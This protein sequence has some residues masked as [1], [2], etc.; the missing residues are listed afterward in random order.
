MR[1][2]IAQYE[3]ATTIRVPPLAA[4][5]LAS[6][7]RREEDVALKL[8]AMRRPPDEAAAALAEADLAG[9]SLYTWNARYALEVAVQALH[10][11]V[12]PF[13]DDREAHGVLEP[14]GVLPERRAD[15]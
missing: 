12:E 10:V 7:M 1:V 2:A 6:T 4:G 14:A 3:G 13:V 11:L 5:L 8:Y 15:E 9:V